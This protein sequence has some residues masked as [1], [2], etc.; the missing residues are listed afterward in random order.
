M[1][2][3]KAAMPVIN[4]KTVVTLV[5]V[6]VIVIAL[7]FL[8]AKKRK[9]VKQKLPIWIVISTYCMLILFSLVFARPKTTEV[10]IKT[11]L[12][13]SYAYIMKNIND[14]ILRGNSF[15]IMKQIF[16]NVAIFVPY[17]FML[18]KAI[19]RKKV[20]LLL[21]PGFSLLIETLQLL[22]HAG[23]FE[24]DDIVHNTLGGIIGFLIY[25]IF[26]CIGNKLKNNSKEHR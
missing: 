3:I 24:L 21:I 12:F 8:I 2:F 4:I 9:I 17:G 26:V 19:N 23:V 25:K 6:W 13:W 5:I 15:T 10:G 22:L 14:K 20:C 7:E 16:L 1:N 18:P 11:E